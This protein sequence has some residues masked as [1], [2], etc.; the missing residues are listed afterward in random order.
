[1]DIQ[2]IKMLL[3]AFGAVIG[4]MLAFVLLKYFSY[5]GN[6]T[7]AVILLAVWFGMGAVALVLLN[8]Q[9]RRR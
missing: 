4:G 5:L 7:I 6:W 1:M 2:K 8:R 9:N 3:F